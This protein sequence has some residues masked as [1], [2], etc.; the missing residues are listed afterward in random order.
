MGMRRS[1]PVLVGREHELRALEEA[2][3]DR[4]ARPVILL[5]GEAGVGKTRLVAELA[6]SVVGAGTA[7]AIGACVH[8]GADALPFA[9]FVDGLGRYLE[10]LGDRA[11]DVL[12]SQGS[13]LAHLIPEL[14]DGA[15]IGA[16]SDPTGPSRGRLYE[17]VR[18]LL[19]RAPEPLMLV[20]EDI[21]WA[22]QS[23]LELLAYLA[24]RLREGRTALVA[25]F[26]IDELHRRHPLV[27]VLAEL[28]RSGRA[29]RLDLE[30]LAPDDVARMVRAVD[31]DASPERVAALAARSDGNPFL[32]EELLS[33]PGGAA[34]SLPSGLRDV[35]FARLG[36]LGE[37]ARRLVSI[38]ATLGRPADVRL[39]Q[40]AWGAARDSSVDPAAAD[41]AAAD[42][43][44]TIR[45]A[46]DR[47]VVVIDP[48]SGRVAFR[49]ALIGEAVADDLLPGE[50]IRIHAALARVLAADPSLASATRAGAAGEIAHHLME[51]RDLPA[52]LRASIV[53]GQ[54]AAAARAYPEARTQFERAVELVE[55]NASG[56]DGT[57]VDRA[58]LLDAA[59]DASFRCGDVARA[60]ALGR[61]AVAEAEAT[62]EPAIS[63]AR[64]SYL[65][66]RLLEWLELSG[67]RAEVDELAERAVSLVPADPPSPQ[68]AY[69]LLA[70]ASLRSHAARDGTATSLAR[71]AVRVAEACGA[72]GVEA[73][74]RAAV[75]I[76]LV[77]LARDDEAVQEIERAV[78][79]AELSR[80]PT[81]ISV[82]HV[83]RPAIY[84]SAGRFG[85]M[86]R[87]L[88]E[89]RAALDAE[90]VLEMTDVFLATDEAE[91]LVAE[92]DWLAAERL[93]D[94]SLAG[95]P[96]RLPRG[97]H[98]I[99]R[100]LLRVRTGRVTD[101]VA[102]LTQALGIEPPIDP[103]WRIAAF[104]G[105]AE[106]AL[107]G[108]QS[109]RAIALVDEAL[110]ILAPSDEVPGRAHLL[111]LGLRA[112]ADL[113]ERVRARRTAE[114]PADGA[115]AEGYLGQ[116]EAAGAGTLVAG[117]GTGGR[118]ETRVRWGRAEDGRRLGTS[119]P[120]A[121]ETAADGL[122][123]YGEPYLAATCRY[124][125]ADAALEGGDR[126]R[127]AMRLREA[128]GF[129][130][131]VGAEPLWTA[132]QSLA[133]RGRIEL[134]PSPDDG[135]T[136]D[137]AVADGSTAKAET[138]CA[139]RPVGGETWT[140]A[141]G[142]SPRE[143]EVLEML[144]DGRTNREIGAA[145]F[146]SDKTA[147]SHV[148]HILDKLGVTSR[149]AAAAVAARAGLGAGDG[150]RPPA[151]RATIG[152]HDA[153]E[154]AAGLR[155]RP[156]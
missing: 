95:E 91:L 121:W 117:A 59:A 101:G 134:A 131:L 100:G 53:A 105:L 92:G 107:E 86:R 126:E 54:A 19:D 89:S 90:G 63:P 102:D 152:A 58:G 66:G 130:R 79:L 29:A 65:L 148:T 36:T 94:R 45:E 76:S 5:G 24:G 17:A 137:G 136:A 51:A 50:R 109:R 40:A 62:G 122:A 85:D 143:V 21:H 156:S 133:R 25:T 31:E 47:A 82:A 151:S 1:C 132:I 60:V 67:D 84:A 106:A 11:T 33:V 81:E 13:D 83:D 55:G 149:G 99:D 4:L 10:T 61:R 129:A 154:A 12:G 88:A 68:R 103:E 42:L 125:A 39:L 141:Y 28:A 37:P 16:T 118:V 115:T 75:A 111:A 139:D 57:G 26:R 73:C 97:T 112:C 114:D 48:S 49:H 74:S 44:A 27:P 108:S 72:I 150:K 138:L 128:A 80:G 110:A 123:R 32:V 142:L 153:I 119:D 7:T 30:R 155:A 23:S 6:A 113:A 20:L 127:A 34:A 135:A 96:S 147:S 71:E 70:L 145:L 87:I 15:D 93:L 146:I 22:D 43:D 38:L 144:L 69:A 52:A 56:L 9:P 2:V 3:G 124:H 46:V 77:G 78:A 18:R 116:L 35:L 41:P 140:D 104:A 120:D 8:L 98:L 14:G 64:L